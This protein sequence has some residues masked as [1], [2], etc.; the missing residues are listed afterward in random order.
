MLGISSILP[1]RGVQIFV[2]TTHFNFRSV[3]CSSIQS[4]R[5]LPPYEISLL[6]FPPYE[7][8]PLYGTYTNHFK[9]NVHVDD[10][11]YIESTV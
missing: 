8:Y 2:W 1:E 9:K 5:K 4:I 11:L 6:K 7:N 3:W 10:V